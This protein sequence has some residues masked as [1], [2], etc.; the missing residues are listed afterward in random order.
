MGKFNDGIFGAFSGRVGNVVGASWRDMDV[1]RKRPRRK[2]QDPSE[3]QMEQRLKFAEVAKFL[4]P[5]KEVVGAYFG[6]T[7]KS[8]SRFNLATSY[9]L[10]NAVV[11][12]PDG[13]YL[14]DYPR[15]MIS[16]GELRGME[17][18]TIQAA[19]NHVLQ[20]TWADNSGQGSAAGTDLLVVVVYESDG[21]FFSIYN[22]AGTRNEATKAITMPAYYFGK[23]VH[24]WAA[25]VSADKKVSSISTYLGHVTA[26]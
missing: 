9:H 5:I 2:K 22:P 14:I 8:K 20:V 19:A 6:R 15:V 18:G 12:A 11:P 25:F 26:Q 24:V 3:K 23:E 13:T 1:L 16:R 4:N 17:E 21:Q 7:E 10:K